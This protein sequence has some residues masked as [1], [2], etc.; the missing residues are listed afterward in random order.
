MSVA[1]Q[2][3]WQHQHLR[4]EV[5][6][7]LVSVNRMTDLPIVKYCGWTESAIAKIIILTQYDWTRVRAKK[8]G[9]FGRKGHRIVYN[10][11]KKISVMRFN[12]TLSLKPYLNEEIGFYDL[13]EH[14]NETI[15]TTS[16][17]DRL[18]LKR[19]VRILKNVTV[20]T[21]YLAPFWY[22]WWSP[23]SNDGILN[24]IE[25]EQSNHDQLSSSSR[26]IC[27]ASKSVRQAKVK[28]NHKWSVKIYQHRKVS[29]LKNKQS[30][31][32]KQ[33]IIVKLTMS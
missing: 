27:S 6:Q 12:L 14:T 15:S 31:L 13:L 7:F 28:K 24:H 29:R 26:I 8:C 33:V 16:I 21:M 22:R 2:H 25:V 11:I 1:K 19:T 32:S 10:Q 20:R 18:M 9:I 5:S 4:L 17:V 23:Q 3:S 30:N